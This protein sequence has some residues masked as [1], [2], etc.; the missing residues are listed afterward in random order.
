LRSLF[1]DL[2]RQKRTSQEG[3]LAPLFIDLARQKRTSQEGR[4]APAVY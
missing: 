2:A 3:W 4:L 1:I